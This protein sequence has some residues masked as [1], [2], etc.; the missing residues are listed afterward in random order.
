MGLD[1]RTLFDLMLAL[2]LASYLPVVAYTFHRSRKQ[3]RESE[4][5]R[6]MV[7]LNVDPDMRDCH[8]LERDAFGLALAVGFAFVVALV[9]LAQLLLGIEM[10]IAETPGLI[11]GG[12][13]AAVL[14]EA[15]AAEQAEMLRHL[16]GYQ[17]GALL[18]YGMAFLGAYLWG[19]QYLARRYAM[20]DLTP[21][22]FFNLAVRMIVAAVVGLLIYHA[23]YLLAGEEVLKGAERVGTKDAYGLPALPALAFFVGMFPQRGIKWL[24]DKLD[25]I[26][27][28]QPLAKPLPLELIEGLDEYDRYRFSEVGI[29]SCH[30][31]A[32]AEFIPLLLR[33]PYHARELIDWILQAKLCVRLNGEVAPLRSVGFR[34]IADLMQ[35]TDETMETLAKE[36]SLSLTCLR[37][38]VLG[39]RGDEELER[40][41]H[42]GK[43][44]GRYT[45]PPSAVDELVCQGKR[46]GTQPPP[47]G[48]SAG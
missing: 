27:G 46:P 20:N 26:G 36:S 14:A 23:A 7:K 42:A 45:V 32:S 47:E 22:A 37:Q 24:S 8:T 12:I 4:I 38:A 10:G 17:H 35:L 3:Q 41:I 18:A 29:D 44:L 13:F 34:T 16:V 9:G 40:L 6:V 15:P 2:L 1:L 43:I 31:L 30:D 5:Q 21:A 11:L 28:G 48:N 33:T 19:L 39:S 25:F